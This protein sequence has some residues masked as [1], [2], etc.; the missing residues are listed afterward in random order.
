MEA[1]LS[2]MSAKSNSLNQLLCTKARDAISF[3][4]KNAKSNEPES[5]KISS[6]NK[7]KISSW[8][9][10][11]ITQTM[12][13]KR[14]CKQLR[15]N[16]E[17]K[18]KTYDKIDNSEPN[19][20]V[21]VESTDQ[22]KELNDESDSEN[23]LL[24]YDAT[25][26][27]QCLVCGKNYAHRQSLARH[28]ENIHSNNRPSIEK[29]PRG[30]PIY[31]TPLYPIKPNPD[32][33]NLFEKEYEKQ[34][35]ADAKGL[36]FYAHRAMKLLPTFDY[37]SQRLIREFLIP[38]L[39]DQR[40]KSLKLFNAHKRFQAE[41]LGNFY[42]DLIKK[43]ND[44]VGPLETMLA[45]IYEA[46]K[47][48]GIRA[49]VDPNHTAT[50]EELKEK[51]ILDYDP[52]LKLTKNLYLDL[53]RHNVIFDR[54]QA[55]LNQSTE[56]LINLKNRVKTLEHQK[57]EVEFKISKVMQSCC[58]KIEKVSKELADLKEERKADKEVISRLESRISMIDPSSAI[59]KNS[60]SIQTDQQ[61]VEPVAMESYEEVNS[62]SVVE[63]NQEPQSKDKKDQPQGTEA[64]PASAEVP[65]DINGYTRKKPKKQV[66]IDSELQALYEAESIEDIALLY[67]DL[68]LIDSTPL[69]KM[70]ALSKKQGNTVSKEER[71]MYK[72]IDQMNKPRAF[73]YYNR[74]HPLTE[75][76]KANPGKTQTNPTTNHC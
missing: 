5:Q 75:P 55:H 33:E 57:L 30:Q 16:A 72:R 52:A 44:R 40:S 56:E 68:P 59:A 28:M 3:G 65:K 62:K 25:M 24:P 64:K 29:A 53:Y 9:D 12:N 23:E 32:L 45:L 22:A 74:D 49:V 76:V 48:E 13:S 1:Q 38:G 42:D 73:Y 19:P 66:S 58:D 60:V 21:V 20:G 36:P 54:Q 15:K 47:V 8:E 39:D 67:K 2:N 35:I 71:A 70:L 14:K 31:L 17:K 37:H 50:A 41:I 51:D 69:P 34:V 18:R 4:T 7:N 46:I 11:N 63:Q 27:N 26:P 43:L 61:D 10:D 6:G